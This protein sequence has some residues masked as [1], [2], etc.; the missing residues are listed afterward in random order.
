MV[1]SLVAI[2]RSS[3]GYIG[4]STITQ[5]NAILDGNYSLVTHNGRGVVMT[6]F[7]PT[8]SCEFILSNITIQGILKM[9]ESSK[10]WSSHVWTQFMQLRIKAWW[11]QDFNGVWSRDLAIAVQRSNQL[12]YEAT[13]V[14]S[15]SFE[16]WN[17]FLTGPLEPSDDQMALKIWPR[18]IFSV[19]KFMF[20]ASVISLLIKI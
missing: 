7:Y 1:S 4:G 13:D 17:S 14:R 6:W 2:N 20:H 11:S 9:N 19:P 18:K 16:G 12:S 10:L 5:H 8:G 3:W 15:G